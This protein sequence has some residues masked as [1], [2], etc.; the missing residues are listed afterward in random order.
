MPIAEQMRRLRSATLIPLAL[1]LALVGAPKPGPALAAASARKPAARLPRG[2]AVPA[3][4]PS[5]LGIGLAAGPGDAWMPDSGIP[6]DYSYQYLAGGANTNGGW[7][8]WNT[9]AQFPLWYAQ[10]AKANGYI[11]F[12]SYYMLLQS[13][14]GCGSC[15]EPQKDLAHL[16]DKA[17]MKAYFQDFR[18]LMKRLG[19]GTWGGIHGFGGTAIVLVEPDF[20]GY[21]E[22]AVIQPSDH[23]WGHCTRAGNS[24]AYLRAAVASSGDPDTKA[25]ANTYQG[26]N[27]ALLHLRATYAPNVLLA[28]HISDWATLFDVG[29]STDPNLDAT[30]LGTKAG[31]FASRSGT[32][33]PG[34]S[35]YDLVTN[36]VLDRDAGYYKSVYGQNRWWDRLN[37]T[38]P[39]FHRWEDYV[40]A[41]TTTSGR[42]AM[43]WQIPLG[44][45]YFQTEDDTDGHYQD[46]RAEYFFAHPQELVDA[47]VIALL[48]GRGNGGSTTYTDDKG[49]GITNPASF[50]TTDG[51]SS[52]QICNDHVSSEPDDDGGY[53]R[54]AAAA[55]YGAPVHL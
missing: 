23:C 48:F 50:C 46:N 22:Q 7:R 26:F 9:D 54:M 17:L 43:V 29:S 41:F 12:F 53:I 36:D 33:G 3:G 28:F 45:Q 24:P 8:Y 6:F 47:G 39:N 14:G 1:A 25:Y 31:L 38:F 35:H 4:L 44:N 40:A 16:N 19:P 51:V 10:G 55:Y 49:D 18:I 34:T 52:G 30:A 42:P 32:T 15:V 2:M 20:S 11:P 27:Q 37:V 21:A 13:S 5:H